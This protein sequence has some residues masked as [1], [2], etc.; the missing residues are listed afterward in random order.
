INSPSNPTSCSLTRDDLCFIADRLAGREVYILADE[1]YRDFFFGE[2][3]GT[4]SEFYDKTI[5]VS[6][7]SKILS[8][9]GWRIGWAVGPE[10]VIRHVTVMR[11]YMSTCA[12]AIS[13]SA[14]I[15]GFSEEGRNATIAMR[16]ELRHRRD[17]MTQAIDRELALPYV[18]GDGAY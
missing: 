16:E 13:Q 15:A 1:I 14:A 10:E 18:A 5:L 9:T 17:V 8:M 3:P 12:S 2:R 6:G 7:L 11:Q 4:M